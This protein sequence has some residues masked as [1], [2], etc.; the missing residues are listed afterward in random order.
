VICIEEREEAS[1][2]ETWS[3]FGDAFKKIMALKV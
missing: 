1:K 3:R 2:E